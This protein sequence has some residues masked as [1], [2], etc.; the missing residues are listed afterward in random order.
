MAV[1]SNVSYIIENL[2]YYAS[3]YSSVLRTTF[4]SFLFNLR[5]G[6]SI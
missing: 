6:A 2:H 5:V 3:V 1:N 4:E